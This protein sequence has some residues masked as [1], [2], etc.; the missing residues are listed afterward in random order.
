[1]CDAFSVGMFDRTSHICNTTSSLSAY[2]V[3]ADIVVAYG[4]MA[5]VVMAWQHHV[6]LI[7]HGIR[8]LL[9]A[10]GFDSFSLVLDI[11]GKRFLKPPPI[12]AMRH[13]LTRT[14]TCTRMHASVARIAC[15][16]A[17]ADAGAW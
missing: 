11:S 16:H 4:V 10:A 14:R 13:A 17:R 7:E 3:M 9:P 5:D 12:D 8:T 2:M 1:M 15:T 6:L